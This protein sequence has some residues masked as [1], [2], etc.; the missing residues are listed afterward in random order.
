MFFEI[1]FG[2]AL[3]MTSASRRRPE[4][5]PRTG[6]TAPVRTS[7]ANTVPSRTDSPWRN[8]DFRTLGGAATLSRLGTNTNTV[9]VAA[10][11]LALTALDALDALTALDASPAQVGTLAAL[12][13]LAFLLI[14]LP[15]GAWVDRLRTRRV[16]ITADLAGPRSSPPYRSRGGSTPSR[17][18]SCTPRSYRAASPP[19]SPTSAPRSS[20][21][22]SSAG[23]AGARAHR[24]GNTH[25]RR[26]HRRPRSRRHPGPGLGHLGPPDGTDHPSNHPLGP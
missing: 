23:R 22:S 17:W 15:A 24:D 2:A 21:R 8:P 9:H 4:R 13:T 19:S 16:P 14:G 10:P 18:G 7:G 20:C 25:G 5:H 26:H 3:S 12:A 6:R 11:L 1:D